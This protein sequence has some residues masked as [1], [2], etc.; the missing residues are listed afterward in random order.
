MNGKS[1]LPRTPYTRTGKCNLVIWPF[2]CLNK[3]L[4]ACVDVMLN[5]KMCGYV[6]PHRNKLLQQKLDN[7]IF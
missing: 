7:L 3:Y 5:L 6:H 4:F 1:F 2:E